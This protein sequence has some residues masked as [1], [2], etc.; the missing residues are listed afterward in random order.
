MKYIYYTDYQLNST[1][2]DFLSHPVSFTT[3]YKPTS[4][5]YLGLKY[6]VFYVD[7]LNP[8]MFYFGL[9]LFYLCSGI[10][11][12]KSVKEGFPIIDFFGLELKKGALFY[13]YTT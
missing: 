12:W 6:F 8:H 3:S 5:S 4:A 7:E 2:K 9:S 13:F 1:L 10:E 11:V